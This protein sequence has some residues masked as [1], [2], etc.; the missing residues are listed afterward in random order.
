MIDELLRTLIMVEAD[1]FAVRQRGRE[2]AAEVGFEGQDQVR[3]ATALSEVGRQMLALVGGAEVIFQLVH[4]SPDELE[5]RAVGRGQPADPEALPRELE[6]AR[7]LMDS[8]S[9][10]VVDGAVTITMARRIPTV[11]GPFTAERVAAIR[12][13]V[14]ALTSSTPLQELAVQNKNLLAS[15]VQIQAQ[16]DELLRLN[17]ELEE[18]N[19]GVMAL[20][21][22]LSDEMEATNRGVVALYAELD[23]K[24]EQ[25]R[26]ANEAKSRFLANVSHELRAPAT[27][28]VGLLRLLLDP[29]SEPVT[30]EQRHQLE[31]A[32]GSADDLLS[33]VNELLDLAKAESGRIDPQWTQVDLGELF[34]TLRGTMQALVTRPELTLTVVDPAGLPVL[35]SDP[36]LLSQI[37]RNLLTNAIKFTEQGEV[38]LAA[39]HT[40]N[41]I[42]LAVTDTGLGIPPDEQEKVFEEFYQIRTSRH[43]TVRGTGLGLPYAR[44]LATLLGGSLALSSVVGAGSTFTVTLPLNP[45]RSA[46]HPGPP[47]ALVLVVDDDPAFR[48]ATSAVLRADGARVVEAGDGRAALAAIDAERPDL[49]LLDL[50]LPELDGGAVLNHLSSDPD[51]AG[52]PVMVLTAF[53]R[54]VAGS[55]LP[56]ATAILGKADTALDELPGLIRRALGTSAG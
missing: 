36:V 1:V 8:W 28:V 32:R 45:A 33:L 39:V 23:E 20:Y 10:A 54:D 5:M 31:L 6:P 42:E 3:I 51:L 35:V 4:A 15:L 9:V 21:S 26:D 48:A 34:D 44:R 50:R 7:R 53:T 11:A 55:L 30:A 47:S 56:R 43:S 41:A 37:L 22:Q 29:R 14:A 27:A 12:E 16:R 13:T 17:A 18:T 38:R 19:R 52:I 46:E 24:S 40:G 25:L 2:V 49:V